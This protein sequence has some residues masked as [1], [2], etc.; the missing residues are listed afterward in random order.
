[1]GPQSRL[2]GATGNADP[3]EEGGTFYHVLM[4]YPHVAEVWLSMLGLFQ[5]IYQAS[6][7]WKSPNLPANVS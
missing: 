4:T 2:I 3:E 7:N 5:R 6:Q 1:M